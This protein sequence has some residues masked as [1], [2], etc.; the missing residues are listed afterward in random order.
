MNFWTQAQYEYHWSFSVY[1]HQ[2]TARVMMY[3]KAYAFLMKKL[4][5]D[6][7]AHLTYHNAQHTKHLLHVVQQLAKAEKTSAHE[8]ELQRTAALFH[9]AAFLWRYDEH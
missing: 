6:L 5:E 4:E 9:D 2:N 8:C 3:D 7:P 1:R